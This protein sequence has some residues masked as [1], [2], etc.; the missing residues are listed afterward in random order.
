M[1]K[2]KAGVKSVT[3]LSIVYEILLILLTNYIY[4]R[5]KYFNTEKYFVIKNE[6]H[7]Y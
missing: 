5:M 4:L 2:E 6:Y 3:S 7:S 1:K